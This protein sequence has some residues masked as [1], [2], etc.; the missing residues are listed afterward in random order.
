MLPNFHLRGFHSLFYPLAF[1]SPGLITV[2]AFF[3]SFFRWS[4]MAHN[5]RY[6]R[7]SGGGDYRHST[8][9]LV[10]A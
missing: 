3:N 8:C 2:T 4:S 9:G 6:N 5:W 1:K 10:G 7:C